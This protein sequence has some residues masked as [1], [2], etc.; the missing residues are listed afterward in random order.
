MTMRGFILALCL[1]LTVLAQASASGAENPVIVE[2]VVPDEATKSV[3][4]A[5]VRGLYGAERVVDR[6]RI[7]SVVAPPSWGENVAKMVDPLLKQ[8]SS[9]ELDIN[10]NSVR[11]SGQVVNEMQRQQVTNHLLTSLNSSYAVN[12]SGLRTGGSPQN[13][14][15][16]V[17]AN[18]IIE[19]ESGSANLTPVGQSILNE[20]LVPMRQIGNARVQIIGHTDNV[21]NPQANVALSQAR[22]EAVR[23]YFRQQGVPD[24][25]LSVL[26][27]GAAQPVA[28]NSTPQGRARNRRIQFKVL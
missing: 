5:K 26:G 6:V 28:D 18:R 27:L 1:S 23:S 9:G 7:D 3:V 8:V 25:G 14:L 21:G 13:L 12:A 2:G 17:L 24:A 15:D 4:L 11:I 16:E 22:A 20:L 19:F 10:G